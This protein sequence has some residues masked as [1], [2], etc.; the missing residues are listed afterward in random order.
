MAV[1]LAVLS[2]RR[3]PGAAP[4]ARSAAS[5]CSCSSMRRSGSSGSSSSPI[6]PCSG[7]STSSI[8]LRWGHRLRY[9][10]FYARARRPS[11]TS[12]QERCRTSSYGQ[13]TSLCETCLELVP[14]KI[15][16]EDGRVF[17][18]KRCPEHGVQKTLI[19]RRRRLLA[20]AARLAEARR[21]PACSRRAARSAAAPATAASAPITSSISCLAI[22]EI[23]DAC[24]LSLPGLL[25][26]QRG[27]ARR[28]S[29]AGRGRGDARRAWSRRGRAGPRP[30]LGWRADH[31][32]P[33]LGDPSTRPG[34]G[35]SG[36]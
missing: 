27:R 34:R 35:R 28:P 30:A 9:A 10:L 12:P 25:R 18:Q 5:M 7:R 24:N 31:P 11:P 4:W 21:P 19:E 36:I 29:A 33:V 8:C 26:R 14:A 3:S 32:S 13:T 22:V 15:I 17:Y 6:R 16:G 2:G 1:F 20:V 23:N